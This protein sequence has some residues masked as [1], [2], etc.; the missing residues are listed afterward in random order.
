[1]M[2]PRRWSGSG[3]VREG[4]E[5]DDFVCHL[6]GS[7]RGAGPD[8]DRGHRDV[9]LSPSGTRAPL[10]AAASGDG[11]RIPDRALAHHRPDPA[12][13]R[14]SAPPAPPGPTSPRPPPPPPPP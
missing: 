11:R 10:A 4:W 9:G 13:P 7:A 5:D 1:M 3:T 8:P 14:R 12:A 6:G 2:S